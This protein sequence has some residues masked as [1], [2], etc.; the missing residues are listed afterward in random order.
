MLFLSSAHLLKGPEVHNSETRYKARCHSTYICKI[1]LIYGY[2]EQLVFLII[3]TTQD[4]SGTLTDLLHDI[5]QLL[6]N[7]QPGAKI[8]NLGIVCK[9]YFVMS[10]M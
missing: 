6:E 8:K 7:I 9:V 4:F 10:C 5:G 1:L 2:G 3:N